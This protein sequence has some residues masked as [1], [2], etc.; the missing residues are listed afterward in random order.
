MH[1]ALNATG[2]ST[3]ASGGNL[4]VSGSTQ[5]LTTTTTNGGATL[6]GTTT[7]TGNLAA[8]SAG[9]VS[10]TGALAVNGT[11]DLSATGQ[12]VTLSNVGNNF[13]GMGEKV[14]EGGKSEYFLNWDLSHYFLI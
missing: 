10:Q 14:C 9:A 6:F 11:T 2:N 7:V 13:G 1:V 12:N 3:L 4:A 5:N 8:T